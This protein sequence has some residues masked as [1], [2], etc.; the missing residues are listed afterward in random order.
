MGADTVEDMVEVEGEDMCTDM[1]QEDTDMRM[2][3]T[4]EEVAM[5]MDMDMVEEVDTEEEVVVIRTLV[6]VMEDIIL[7]VDT[8]M[9]PIHPKVDALNCIYNIILNN[10]IQC[11]NYYYY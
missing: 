9:V 7:V 10:T 2:V 11:V 1:V 8:D 3:D 5:D 4:E 6:D